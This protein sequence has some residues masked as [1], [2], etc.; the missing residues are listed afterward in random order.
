M[1]VVEPLEHHRQH[2]PL[3]GV[4][5]VAQLAEQGGQLAPVIPRFVDTLQ[6]GADHVVFDPHLVQGV[7]ETGGYRRRRVPD[8]RLLVDA[9]R[10]DVERSVGQQVDRERPRS[11]R[12]EGPVR[13]LAEVSTVQHG[14]AADEV[15]DRQQQLALRAGVAVE[16]AIEHPRK[17]VQRAGH[18]EPL[19][20]RQRAARTAVHGLQGVLDGVEVAFGPAG[21]ADRVEVAGDR[22]AVQLARPVVDEV[23]GQEVQQ[24]PCQQIARMQ[25]LERVRFGWTITAEPVDGSCLPSSPGWSPHNDV[26]ARTAGPMNPRARRRKERFEVI[27]SV[28]IHSPAAAR[29]LAR[30]SKSAGFS[31]TTARRLWTARSN[32]AASS[33]PTVPLSSVTTSRRLWAGS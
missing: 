14:L 3:L 24:I 10:P 33:S 26:S 22:Q 5:V 16:V 12:V 20:A 13:L 30:R 2:R 17:Q 7:V 25:I 11:R 31:V 4:E 1:L 32:T 23:A 9:W 19:L 8:R 29:C 6:G 28:G 27:T 15:D 21:S 18:H